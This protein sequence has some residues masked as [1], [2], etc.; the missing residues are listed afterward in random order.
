MQSPVRL[1]RAYESPDAEEGRRILV[2]RLWPRGLKKAEA[3]VDLWL[4]DI[5]PSDELR[6][7][8][9]HDR[10]RWPEFERRYRGELATNPAVERLRAEIAAGPVTLVFAAKDEAHN[11]AVA[12]ARYL[13]GVRK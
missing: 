7:W 1:K 6:R 9:G 3:K 4:K 8:F 11:N 5:A 13:E 12:L 10:A 2:D